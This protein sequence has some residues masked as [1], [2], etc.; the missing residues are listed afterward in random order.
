MREHGG[1]GGHVEG[2]MG[3]G[4]GHGDGM[5]EGHGGWGGHVEGSMGGGHGH[6]DGM[7]GGHGHGHSGGMGGG[8]E[9]SD[10]GAG[11]LL[12]LPMLP[13]PEFEDDAAGHARWIVA[14]SL[15]TTVSTVSSSKEGRPFGNIRSIADGACFLGSSGLPYFYL[16]GPDPSAVD[17]Q[18]NPKV[19]LSFT[20]AALGERVGSDGRACG[21]KD[22][23]DP[24]C[25]K[26]TLVGTARALEGEDRIAAAKEAFQV[27]HPRASWLSSGGAH[28]G[29]NYYT[30]DLEDIVFLRNYGGFTAVSP[31]EYLNWK[32]DASKLTGEP[33]CGPVGGGSATSQAAASTA[34]PTSSNSAG[35]VAIVVLASFVGSFAGGLVS[36]KLK[37]AWHAKRGGYAEASS[38]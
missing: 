13:R 22:A 9:H 28:T 7:G 26:L 31:A 5:G 11:S 1:W 35:I 19:A 12:V 3:G 24:T 36:D 17:I 18:S 37:G 15:W 30:L 2:S 14:K 29:G 16:P 38:A 32:P 21:G 20:E 8:H 10:H 27:Q 25:A 6:G 4:H 23:E 34:A 33:P